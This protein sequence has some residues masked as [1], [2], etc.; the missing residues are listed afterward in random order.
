MKKIIGINDKNKNSI[1]VGSKCYNCIYL[2]AL[3][4]TDDILSD[5]IVICGKLN[6]EVKNTNSYCKYKVEEVINYKVG[7]RVRTKDNLVNF[8][9][10]KGVSY[11]DYMY[12]KDGIITEID[13]MSN[14]KIYYINGFSYTDEMIEKIR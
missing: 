7:D 10:Y 13:E 12:I 2:K 5:N 6:K 8:A 9:K 11:F 14:K 3:K 4:I 1:T